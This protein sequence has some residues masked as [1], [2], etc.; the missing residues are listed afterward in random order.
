MGQAK[1]E[2]RIDEFFKAGGPVDRELELIP[3]ELEGG[4]TNCL[5]LKERMRSDLLTLAQEKGANFASAYHSRVGLGRYDY[6]NRIQTNLIASSALV[7]H[8]LA[9]SQDLL[10]T[11]EGAKVEGTLANLLIGWNRFWSWDGFLNLIGQGKQAG[12]VL[13]AERA[14]KFSEYLQRAP[15]LKGMVKLF[16]IAIFPWLV[17]FVV[18]GRWRIL[19]S[20]FAIYVSVLLWTPLW[21]LLY[22]LMTSIALSTELMEEFG[23][24][25]DGVSLYAASFITSKL[26]QFY[27]IYS[28]LQLFVGPLPTMLLSYGL[29]SSMLKDSE[30]EQ[31]PQLV[32]DAKDIGM[33][34]ATGGASGAASAVIRKV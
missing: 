25:S 1:A 15:H 27:A 8:Y 33:G 21:T 28:W 5:T 11:E 26:Y 20:W 7:N 6:T 16:L 31:A 22:H 13:T 19:V 30:G 18:A 32:S 4:K 34:A 23:R 9:K 29:F 17:F 2:G 12:A 10:G 3:V 24:V 14:T